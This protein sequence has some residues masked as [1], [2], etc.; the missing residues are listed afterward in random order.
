MKYPP[1][2][3]WVITVTILA[4]TVLTLYHFKSDIRRSLFNKSV[5]VAFDNAVATD[6]GVKVVLLGSSHIK[7]SISD[8]DVLSRM[9]NQNDS[10]VNYSFV[11]IT[12][13][14]GM[15]EDYSQNK[16]LMD[17]IN[18]Y[19]PTYIIIQES[20]SFF[21][22]KRTLYS[23]GL[24]NDIQLFW[25][26]KALYDNTAYLKKMANSA[27]CDIG[28]STLKGHQGILP[29][30]RVRSMDNTLSDFIKRLNRKTI[31]L[32]I[33]LPITIERK[34][35]SVRNTSKY[36]SL[37]KQEQAL[38]N[39]SVFWFERPMPHKFYYDRSHMN[40]MGEDIYTKWFIETLHQ[41]HLTQLADKINDARSL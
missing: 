17:K 19:D 25:H 5:E 9:A 10:N 27:N 11:K 18:S 29:A 35:D 8:P 33:P 14:S 30:K 2:R 23:L 13:G 12:R 3:L 36:A 24:Q 37:F 39:F 34:L 22:R 26:L 4:T 6:G 41:F 40:N 16:F 7:E 32:H 15:L 1:L 28:D 31:I 20:I 21:N 38:S